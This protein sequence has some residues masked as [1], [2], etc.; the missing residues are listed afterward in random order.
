MAIS[1]SPK[2]G[3]TG[4]D[5]ISLSLGP[6]RQSLRFYAEVQ[7]SALDTF[8][9]FS[10]MGTHPFLSAFGG[11]SERNGR[12]IGAG[13]AVEPGTE[14]ATRSSS[15]AAKRA[16]PGKRPAAAKAAAT[17]RPAPAKPAAAKAAAAKRPA[18]AKPAAAKPAAAKAA[19]KAAVKSAAPAKK[20]AKKA[21]PAKKA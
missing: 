13:A 17:K 1:Q 4:D 11:S 8:I 21:S 15:P 10:A 6:V 18:A 12:A 16:A 20:A 14:T 7:R 9:R 5:L 3:P 2:T 19:P